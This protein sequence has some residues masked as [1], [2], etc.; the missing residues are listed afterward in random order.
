M[1]LKMT[2]N[3]VDLALDSDNEILFV[4]DLVSG[5]YLLDL[6]EL[7]IVQDSRYLFNIHG[8]RLGKRSR[9]RRLNEYSSRRLWSG[10]S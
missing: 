10:S 3:L 1:I 2:I 7:P 8:S 5:I 4:G 9:S 6:S